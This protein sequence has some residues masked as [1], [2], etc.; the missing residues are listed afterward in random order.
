MIRI[1][2]VFKINLS[3]Y[4]LTI[5]FCDLL[6]YLRSLIIS[7]FL[8]FFFYNF[9]VRIASCKSKIFCDIW[10]RLCF[11]W[12]SGLWSKF[13]GISP[14]DD[15]TFIYYLF[16]LNAFFHYPQ[17]ITKKKICINFVTNILIIILVA[18]ISL[19]STSSD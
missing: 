16:K 9:Q 3:C 13:L 4:T 6:P 1:Q 15:K 8:P 18:L 17:R 19:A 14:E 10:F 2:D 12:L 5:L 7:Q 11:L